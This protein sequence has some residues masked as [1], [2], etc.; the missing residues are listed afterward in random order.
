MDASI[1]E[2]GEGI[3]EMFKQDKLTG[4]LGGEAALPAASVCS[5]ALTFALSL[6][7]EGRFGIS[8]TRK[9]EAMEG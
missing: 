5:A 7:Q 6:G 1:S 2:A 9:D 4:D 3:E 8:S